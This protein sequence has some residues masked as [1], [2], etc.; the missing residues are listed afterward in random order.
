MVI[1]DMCIIASYYQ[2]MCVAE[3]WQPRASYLTLTNVARPGGA[4]AEISTTTLHHSA[5][6]TTANFSHSQI[7][8]L[9]AILERDELMSA[10]PS[11]PPGIS[12][13]SLAN[14]GRGML[15]GADTSSSKSL[16]QSVDRII[17]LI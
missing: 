14:V 5:W 16:V 4:I 1:V 15:W 10:I 17:S 11:P 6:L 9:G 12:A 3:S 13:L 7:T 8:L 2:I